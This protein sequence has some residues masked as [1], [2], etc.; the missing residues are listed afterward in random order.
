M[1]AKLNRIVMR[2]YAKLYRDVLKFARRY[3]E[4]NPPVYEK[5]CVRAGVHLAAAINARDEA[6][7]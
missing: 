2:Q 5:W 6:A 7:P 4:T 3:A 1:N